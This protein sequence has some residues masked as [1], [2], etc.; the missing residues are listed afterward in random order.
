MTRAPGSRPSYGRL[1]TDV[2]RLREGEAAARE[3][4]GSADVRVRELAGAVLDTLA[5][6]DSADRPVPDGVGAAA[7][8]GGAWLPDPRDVPACPVCGRRMGAALRRART[9]V[10]GP[11]AARCLGSGQPPVRD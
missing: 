3:L 1:M 2:G 11:V 7:S 5:H 4:V 6:S 9:P 8:P 10:H